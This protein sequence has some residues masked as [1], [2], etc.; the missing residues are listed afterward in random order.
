MAYFANGTDGDCY[1]EKYCQHCVH[2]GDDNLMC[3]VLY[4]HNE[5]NYDACN[6]DAKDADAETKAKHTA[7]NVLWPRRGSA[8]GRCAMFYPLLGTKPASVEKFA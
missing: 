5:W 4:L 1:E 3:A 6:G 8:N 7:L 2:F